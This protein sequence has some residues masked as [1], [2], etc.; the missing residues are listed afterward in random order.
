MTRTLRELTLRSQAR[1]AWRGSGPRSVPMDIQAGEI[2]Y[3]E[4]DSAIVLSSSCQLVRGSLKMAGD[5][6]IVMLK[7]GVHRPRHR[8]EGARLQPAQGR[9]A[10]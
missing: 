10:T 2:L 5:S 4:K 3:K 6:A 7:E 9:P 8:L 1:V